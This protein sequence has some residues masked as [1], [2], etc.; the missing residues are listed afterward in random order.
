LAVFLASARAGDVPVVVPT[1]FIFTVMAA[2]LTGDS[3]RYEAPQIRIFQALKPDVVAIQE[4]NY[5][6]KTPAQI[7]SFVD[8]A[9]GTNYCYYR[10]SITNWSYAIP[11]GIISRF[12]ILEAGS[13]TNAV[14]SDRGFA[15][16]RIQ[17]PGPNELYLWSVHLKASSSDASKRAA[18]ATNLADLIQAHVPSNAWLIVAGD[19]NTEGRGERCLLKLKTL[20]SDDAIPTDAP[21]GGNPATNKGRDKPFDYVLPAF[22]MTN[23]LVPVTVGGQVF[24]N[25]LVFDSRVFSPLASVPPVLPDDATNCQHM[26]ALKA[27]RAEFTLTNWLNV[28][29]PTLTV[30]SNRQLCWISQSNLSYT[31]LT[32]TNLCARTVWT[33]AGTATSPTASFVFPLTNNSGGQRFYRVTCP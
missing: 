11:N 8:T 10:E 17:L 14:V 25:G 13:W 20:L 1:N 2:N 15:W 22:S 12:P 16:A 7:R 19:L 33:S 28:S 29:C 23:R 3:Q 21:D 9:F 31:V 4:F 5:S 6:N 27:F 30:V 26:A 32:S 24:S 18:Q